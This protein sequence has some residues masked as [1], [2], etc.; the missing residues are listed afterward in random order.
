MNNF[1][2]NV[3]NKTSLE[4]NPALWQSDDDSLKQFPWTDE[5]PLLQQ[6]SSLSL[7]VGFVGVLGFRRLKSIQI[8]L[9][10][11]QYNPNC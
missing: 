5:H 11:I 2:Q 4:R 10:I 6:S 9:C 3:F 8:R 1:V 7:H